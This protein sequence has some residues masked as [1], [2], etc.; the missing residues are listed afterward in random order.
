MDVGSVQLEILLD[1]KKIQRFANY[2]TFK[3]QTIVKLT[4]P[5]FG[6]HYLQKCVSVKKIELGR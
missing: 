2:S 5:F 3:G 4:F 6:L 1:R